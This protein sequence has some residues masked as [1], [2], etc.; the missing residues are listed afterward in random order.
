V[1]EKQQVAQAA[2]R[3]NR[4]KKKKKKKRG[5]RKKQQQT[6]LSRHSPDTFDLFGDKI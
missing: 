5:S 4:I 2:G 3:K 6:H 1:L